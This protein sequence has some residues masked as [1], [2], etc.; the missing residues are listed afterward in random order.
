MLIMKRA[1]WMKAFREKRRM[2]QQELAAQSGLSL[3][4]IQEL[5]NSQSSRNFNRSTLLLLAQGLGVPVQTVLNGG[6]RELPREIPAELPR[7]SNCRGMVLIPAI[8]RVSASRLEESTDLGYPERVASGTFALPDALWIDPD[9]FAVQIEGDCML[10][11]YAPGEWV[12]CSPNARFE[13]GAAYVV[14]LDGSGDEQNSVKLVFDHGAE[15]FELVP[16]NGRHR[17]KLILKSS[18]I[19]MA[20]VLYKITPVNLSGK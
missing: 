20:R 2:T 4:T 11:H 18:V 1:E 15:E 10:P 7:A 19:R 3:A 5:E 12:V 6:A 14:Q 9:M 16:A 17:R 8:N 13:E